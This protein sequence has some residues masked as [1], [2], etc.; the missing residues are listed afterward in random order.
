MISNVFK[1]ILFEEKRHKIVWNHK[2]IYLCNV[3]LVKYKGFSGYAK[4]L[5]TA[6]SLFFSE[7]N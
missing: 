6:K 3:I 4:R 1:V 7:K 5:T 2:N